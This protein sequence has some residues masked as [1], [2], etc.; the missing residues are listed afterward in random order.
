MTSVVIPMSNEYVEDLK[1]EIIAILTFKGGTGKTTTAV[2]LARECAKTKR[3]LLVDNAPQANS[4]KGLGYP[5]TKDDITIFEVLSKQNPIREAI[6]KTEIPNLDLIPSNIKYIRRKVELG[7]HSVRLKNALKE[8]ENDY[9]V[10]I[11]DNDP[12]YSIVTHNALV[13]ANHVL[14]PIRIDAYALDG[15]DYLL[16]YVDEI[17]DDYNPDLKVLGAFINQYES[18]TN[19]M[20]SIKKQLYDSLGDLMLNTVVRKNIKLAEAPFTGQAIHD[21]DHKA[22]GAEDFRSLA[23]EVLGL[24]RTKQAG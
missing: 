7:S 12:D 21:Y 15:F 23:E 18:N 5:Q 11:I 6:I 22:A 3:T 16:E 17:K 24:V 8:V 9:D 13:A 2:N 19:L 10:I 4:S 20:K 1:A 14:I